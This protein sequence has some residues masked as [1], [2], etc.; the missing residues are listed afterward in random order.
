MIRILHFMY[1]NNRNSDREHVILNPVNGTQ[2]IVYGH[3][4]DQYDDRLKNFQELAQIESLIYDNLVEEAYK[5]IQ[6]RYDE[7]IYRDGI[8]KDGRRNVM[9]A[10]IDIECNGFTFNFEVQFLI[11]SSIAEY[12]HLCLGVPLPELENL[13]NSGALREGDKVITIDTIVGILKKDANENRDFVQGAAVKKIKEIK[14]TE[15]Q[16]QYKFTPEELFYSFGHYKVC[17]SPVALDRFKKATK[18]VNKK[19][20]K[21]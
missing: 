9:I 18:N 1:L 2:V 20:C 19:K 3:N 12:D 5:L 6:E 21:R 13:I 10:N 15:D 8:D 16:K 7:I 11:K 17:K 14:L 4:R